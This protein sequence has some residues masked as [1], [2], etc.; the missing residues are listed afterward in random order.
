MIHLWQE[1]SFAFRG[2]SP[3]L[4]TSSKNPY[5]RKRSRSPDTDMERGTEEGSRDEEEV[6]EEDRERE[7]GKAV[8]QEMKTGWCR[9]RAWGG[10]LR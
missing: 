3:R 6:S 2:C 4:D 8:T 7:E 1:E 5:C 9:E 10:G